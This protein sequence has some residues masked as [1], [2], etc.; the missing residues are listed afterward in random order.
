[1]LAHL[2]ELQKEVAQREDDRIWF[3]H[4]RNKVGGLEQ[5]DNNT[6]KFFRNQAKLD[7]SKAK[8]ENAT[9]LLTANLEK[10]E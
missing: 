5:T 4:Y 10:C 3:D 6:E 7:T 1:M 8:F 9:L 2:E